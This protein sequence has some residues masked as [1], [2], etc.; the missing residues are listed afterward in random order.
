MSDN[1]QQP[2][3]PGQPEVPPQQPAPPA[4]PQQPA[5]GAPPQGAPAAPQPPY[6]APT[7]PYAQP[8]PQQPPYAQP[9]YGGPAQPQYPQQPYAQ[10]QAYPGAAPAYP[11]YAAPVAGGGLAI[12]ALIVGIV[13]F[14]T[15]WIPIF[16]LL[17]AIVGIVLGILVVRKPVRRG[18]GW[19]AIGLSA[20]AALTNIIM[21]VVVF[22]G[23]ALFWSAVGS[24][25]SPD[26]PYESPQDDRDTQGDADAGEVPLDESSFSVVGGQAI[27]TPCWSYDGPQYFV[28]NIDSASV[29]DCIGKLELWGEWQDDVFVP[30]GAGST[31]GQILADPQ[32]VSTVESV[33][34]GSDVNAFVDA[35][36]Q[37]KGY[38]SSQGEIISLHE[39]TTIG[40]VPANITRIDSNAETT[41]TK[42]FITVLAPHAYDT[43]SGQVQMFLISVTT[44][45][46]NGEEQL[47][48]V[49][50]TW[51]WK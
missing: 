1:G 16:G 4:P 41:H 37:Q 28:N 34:P 19:T 29:D 13:A 18:F 43:P 5:P 36:E 24:T 2:P 38:F 6:G 25:P 22:L 15:G 46:Q 44:P 31:A 33:V 10:P 48:H 14:V 51:T 17:V 8:A 39:P 42:A 47:Q 40:G 21:I 20:L 12:A 7:S 27:D 35:V 32:L 26:A 50:D 11:A 23:P 9:Q 30:T 45:Y 3:V 49:I